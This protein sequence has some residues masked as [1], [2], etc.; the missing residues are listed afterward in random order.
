[1]CGGNG[2]GVGGVVVG[3]GGSGVRNAFYIRSIC[4][5][6]IF[7]LLKTILRANVLCVRTLLS[8]TFVH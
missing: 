1:M 5:N 6:K 7:K 3:G 4:K 8:V 2:G